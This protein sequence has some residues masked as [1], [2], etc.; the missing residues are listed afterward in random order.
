MGPLQHARDRC[1]E[2]DQLK[3]V[4]YCRAARCNYRK[5]LNLHLLIWSSSEVARGGWKA[6]IEGMLME[7]FCCYSFS[8]SLHIV[9]LSCY[10]NLQWRY[11]SSERKTKRFFVTALL[12]FYEWVSLHQCRYLRVQH[13]GSCSLL[14]RMRSWWWWL[15]WKIVFCTWEFALSY[16]AL[17]LFSFLWK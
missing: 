16:C 1:V 5:K 3:I 2:D 13:T 14:V 15:C 10:R 6:H 9:I 8:F 17:C 7:R 11:R 12:Y 4:L